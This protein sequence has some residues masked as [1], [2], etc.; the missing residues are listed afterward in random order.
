MPRPSA[1]PPIA[2]VIL[3]GGRSTRLGGGDKGL[4]PL[5]GRPILAQVIDRLR[6]Q[7]AP[8]ALNANGDPAR[9]SAFGLPVL[10]DGMPDHPGP[11][12]GILA[13]M[14]WAA[15]IGVSAVVTVAGDTPVFP[16]DL[17]ARLQAA[18]RPPVIALTLDPGGDLRAHPTFGL[19]PTALREVLRA[20][21]RAGQRRVRGWA[22]S[23]GCSRAIFPAAPDQFFNINTPED[24][25]EAT[26]RA[27]ARA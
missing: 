24:L 23:Q 11:L 20:D 18:G 6:P 8:L 25:A 26:A 16:A 27:A 5:G 12:A 14:D 4:L 9:F 2:G 15:A 17:V 13:A 1:P 3:A 7:A 22:E 19:W 21:L 10:P